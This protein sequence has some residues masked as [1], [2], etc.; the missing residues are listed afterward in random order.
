MRGI[1]PGHDATA[2]PAGNAPDLRPVG[3][4]HRVIAAKVH[5][6]ADRKIVDVG[7]DGFYGARALIAGAQRKGVAVHLAD[8]AAD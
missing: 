1:G 2:M 4:P 5:F 6:V 3:Q 8:L 7:P